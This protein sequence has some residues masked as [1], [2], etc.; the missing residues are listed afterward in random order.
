MSGASLIARNR[1]PCILTAKATNRREKFANVLTLVIAN[2][3]PLALAHATTEWWFISVKGDALG[4]NQI[5]SVNVTPVD[6]IDV[7]T[8]R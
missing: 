3:I 5:V 1:I 6:E 7:A 4:L 8:A 2:N